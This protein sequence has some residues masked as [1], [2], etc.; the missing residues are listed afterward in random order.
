MRAARTPGSGPAPSRPPIVLADFEGR[1]YGEILKTCYFIF[2][3]GDKGEK[4][5]EVVDQ[6]GGLA[7]M[8]FQ[9]AIG[10][11]AKAAGDA[12]KWGHDPETS[13]WFLPGA[14]T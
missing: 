8:G 14:R 4:A 11:V 3:V 12:S 13:E 1:D 7:E 9:A 6:L 5:G 2:D 10:A